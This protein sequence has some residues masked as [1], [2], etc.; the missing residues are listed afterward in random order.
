LSRGS[1]DA[2]DQCLRIFCAFLTEQHPQ[3]TCFAQITRPQVE[4]F[5]L[6][7]VSRPGS[8]TGS[9]VTAN[10][11]HQRLGMLRTFLE[12]I[13]EWDWPDAPGRQ[14]ITIDLPLVDRPLPKFL[15]DAQAAALLRTASAD[16][17]DLR[18]LIVHM[19]LR[20]GLRTSERCALDPQA[21]VQ[22]RDGY[23]LRVPV[24]K[25][26]N[27]RYVPLHP[28]LVELLK[29][30]T[31]KHPPAGSRLI[32]RRNKPLTLGIVRRAVEHCLA[33]AGIGYVHPHQLR[34]PFA[35]Q[36]I[37]RGMRVEAIGAMLGA[38]EPADDAGL[39]PHC[40]QDRRAGVPGR[41]RQRRHPLR[42]TRPP[43]PQPQTQTPTRG[44]R[45]DAHPAARTPK[46]ARQRLVHPT[47]EL[48][49][50]FETVCE[51][52]GV[53]QSTIELRPTLQAQHDDAASKQQDGR[54]Q[55]FQTLL[56][57]QARATQGPTRHT[58]S[59]GPPGPAD[60]R[61]IPPP[62]DRITGIT[63]LRSRWQPALLCC[64]VRTRNR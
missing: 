34:H 8:K 50:A 29:D 25:L 47:R 35:T 40:R 60:H 6:W 56:D 10:T 12:R 43:Q 59:A 44:D 45:R 31:S 7:L 22:M 32:T 30:W 33:A 52:C 16:S 5:K 41:Q 49:C 36:A 13:M 28:H 64:G 15:D 14:P 23:W 18:T 2:A 58:T 4:G 51:G 9:H 3:V 57:R 37:N 27:D 63:A 1:V 39:C 61:H 53:F 17:N 55:M 42:R 26:H 24:G 11:V 62:L 48:D 38:P 54:A 19:L 46:D 20:T 21:V